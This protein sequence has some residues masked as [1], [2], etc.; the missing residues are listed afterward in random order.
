MLENYLRSLILCQPSY[1]P[2]F[3][4]LLKNLSKRNTREK[5]DTPPTIEIRFRL[6]QILPNRHPAIRSYHK[7]KQV[8][9]PDCQRKPQKISC[10]CE[11]NNE[12]LFITNPYFEGYLRIMTC[13]I[14]Q[15][16]NEW[17]TFQKKK[18]KKPKTRKKN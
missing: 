9:C 11:R 5:F 10:T 16:I 6:I 7:Q 12:T 8:S 2:A 3:N 4:S 1:F 18:K 17:F 14:N 13:N 15:H